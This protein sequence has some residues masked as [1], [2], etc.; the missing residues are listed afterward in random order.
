[1][2]GECV[3]DITGSPARY[4][5]CAGCLDTRWYTQ[6]GIPAFGFGPG[7]LE[8]SHGPNEYVEEAALR[9]VAAVYTLFAAKLFNRAP[10]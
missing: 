3:T 9:R 10:A 1:M 8:V 2:L 7:R 6:L 4:E 5:L